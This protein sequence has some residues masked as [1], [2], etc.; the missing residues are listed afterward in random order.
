MTIR[1]GL[2][3]ALPVAFVLWYAIGLFSPAELARVLR[4]TA[5]NL[6]EILGSNGSD[7][8]HIR[9]EHKHDDI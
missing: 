2:L 5:D 3:I 7:V 8:L 6:D 9:V 1:L 4:R